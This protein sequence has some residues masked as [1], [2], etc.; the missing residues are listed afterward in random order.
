MRKF[1]CASINPIYPEA[2]GSKV[3]RPDAEVSYTT[4]NLGF[5]VGM[6]I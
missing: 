1:L 2:L 3:S 6:A 4:T 5:S